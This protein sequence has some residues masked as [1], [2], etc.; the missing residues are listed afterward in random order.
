M[1][2]ARMVAICSIALVSSARELEGQDLSQYR[3]FALGSNVASVSKLA[4][5]GSSA[6]TTTHQRPALLQDLEWRPSH[7]TSGSTEDSTDPVEQMLFSFYNDQLFRIIVDY[8]QQR[9]GGMTRADMVEAI[10][11]VYGT[12]VARTSPAPARAPSRLESESGSVVARWG[13]ADHTVVLYQTVTYGSAFRL[14]VRQAHLADLARDAETRALRL[15]AQ[16]APQKEIVRQK[17]QV[18]DESA[19][20]AKARTV[21]KRVFRP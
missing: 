20:V 9:T 7:W 12:P 2:S 13:D 16:E 15:D 14:V 3:T 1:I 4:D 10:S 11:A 17:K 8:A 19:A 5:G 21:N 6:V 18:E